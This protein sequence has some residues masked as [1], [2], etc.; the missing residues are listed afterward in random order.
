MNS[1]TDNGQESIWIDGIPYTSYNT[2]L[3]VKEECFWVDGESFIF[4][5]SDPTDGSFL[6]FF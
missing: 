2:G 6:E 5:M 1:N 3:P 4:L